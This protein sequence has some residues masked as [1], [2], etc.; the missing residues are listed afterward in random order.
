MNPLPCE[1]ACGSPVYCTEPA[2]LGEEWKA[3][4]A[5]HPARFKIRPLTVEA[6][7]RRGGSADWQVEKEPGGEP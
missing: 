6:G 2:G 7:I 5:R 1:S 3:F 4:V